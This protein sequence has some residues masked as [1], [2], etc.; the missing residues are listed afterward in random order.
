M[1]WYYNEVSAV[2]LDL[3]GGLSSPPIG[4]DWHGRLESLPHMDEGFTKVS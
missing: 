1:G 3:W 4:P 2:G